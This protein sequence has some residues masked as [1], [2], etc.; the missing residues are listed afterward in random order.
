[1]RDLVVDLC[2]IAF[3]GALGGFMNAFIGDSSLHLPRMEEGVWRPGYIG[4]VFVGVVAA[5]A[6]WLTTQPG[7]FSVSLGPSPGV[8]L[9]LSELSTAIV[10]GFGGARWFKAELDTTIYRRAAAVAA[11]K[12]ANRESAAAIATGSP[13]EAL[14]IAN[15]ME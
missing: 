3:C 15:R 2:V 12:S 9:R 7:S 10:V 5:I 14:R 4:V 6:A 8:T 11:N 13:M 1:M